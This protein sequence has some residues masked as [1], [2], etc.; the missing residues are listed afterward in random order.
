M[1]RRNAG[2]EGGMEFQ[3]RRGFSVDT[4]RSPGA[5]SINVF[6]AGLTL[7]SRFRDRTNETLSARDYPYPDGR[8]A[9]QTFVLGGGKVFSLLATSFRWNGL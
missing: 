6:L 7:V 2:I 3:R 5:V 8:G 1:R 4:T 9:R